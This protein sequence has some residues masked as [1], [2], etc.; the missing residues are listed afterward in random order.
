M[1][2]HATRHAWRR[3]RKAIAPGEARGLAAD[4]AAVIERDDHMS[5]AE[6]VEFALTG[7]PW[8]HHKAAS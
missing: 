7:E 2:R 4:I 8:D 1:R 3:V 6:A 5:L